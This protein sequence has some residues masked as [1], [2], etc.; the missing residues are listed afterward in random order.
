MH[1]NITNAQSWDWH[2]LLQGILDP[3]IMDS[4]IQ[5][6]IQIYTSYS[7]EHNHLLT[8]AFKNKCKHLQFTSF[9]PQIALLFNHKILNCCKVVVA[10]KNYTW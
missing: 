6:A 10:N 8:F 5:L 9:N 2:L 7:H 4:L 1:K 3:G